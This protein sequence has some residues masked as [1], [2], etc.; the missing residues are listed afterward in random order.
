MGKGMKA[1]K[2]P[3]TGGG[4]SM[5]KQ[6]KK[7]QAVQ[8]KMDEVQKE[9]DEMEQTATAGGGAVSVTVNGKKQLT[10]LV[11]DP[12]IVEDGDLEMLQDLIMAA[13]NEALR[14]MEE[15]ASNEMNKLTGGLG[16]PEG[17]I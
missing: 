5:Q 4:G 6:M 13:T 3:K 15:V 14:Q 17:L 12:E 10:D 1:G 8:Q 9:I 16:L 11:L 7:M 2:R